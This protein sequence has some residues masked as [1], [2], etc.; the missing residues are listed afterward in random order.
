[1]EIDKKTIG[2]TVSNKA[3]V[4]ILI[5]KGWF[6]EQMDAARFA[7]SIAIDDSTEPDEIEGAETVWNVGSFDTDGELRNIIPILYPDITTPY[8]LIEYLINVGLEKI[9]EKIKDPSFEFSSLFG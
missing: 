1:M 2:L 9:G 5:Q 8:R 3:V 4:E 6:N 7:M